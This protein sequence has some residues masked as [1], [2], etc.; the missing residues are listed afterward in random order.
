MGD[1]AFWYNLNAGQPDADNYS[2]L[3]QLDDCS[4]G[5]DGKFQFM[6]KWPLRAGTNTNIWKQTNNPM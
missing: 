2:I 5:S 6:I 4:R 3:S 1:K